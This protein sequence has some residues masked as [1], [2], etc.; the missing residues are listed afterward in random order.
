MGERRGSRHL[1]YFE[2]HIWIRTRLTRGTTTRGNTFTYWTPG[3]VRINE[4]LSAAQLGKTHNHTITAYITDITPATQGIVVAVGGMTGGYA[5]YIK[6]N[7]AGFTFN[8]LG[9][10]RTTIRTP[11]ALPAQGAVELRL[12]VALIPSNTSLTG[13]GSK[14]GTALHRFGSLFRIHKSRK[15]HRSFTINDAHSGSPANQIHTFKAHLNPSNSTHP[16]PSRQSSIHA[17]VQ[18]SNQQHHAP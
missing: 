11:D 9:T 7:R 1:G 8:F 13:V 10:N 17:L 18:P 6:D 3:A 16:E 15:K 4:P 5:L 12:D 14:G 2:H